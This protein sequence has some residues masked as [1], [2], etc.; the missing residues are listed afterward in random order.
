MSSEAIF[1]IINSKVTKNSIEKLINKAKSAKDKEELE[2]DLTI[3]YEEIK[4]KSEEEIKGMIEE[5]KTKDSKK[6]KIKQIT[7]VTA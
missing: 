1:D 6:Q 7:S 2:Q 5:A 4:S 3:I